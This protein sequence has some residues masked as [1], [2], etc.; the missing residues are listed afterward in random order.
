MDESPTIQDG[1]FEKRRPQDLLGTDRIHHTL[2]VMASELGLCPEKWL[3]LMCTPMPRH[4]Q[5]QLHTNDPVKNCITVLCFGCTKW[6]EPQFFCDLST[7]AQHIL[8]IHRDMNTACP[9]PVSIHWM[10]RGVLF[11]AETSM[12]NNNWVIPTPYGSSAL[13]QGTTTPILYVPLLV[14]SIQKYQIQY[15]SEAYITRTVCPCVWTDDSRDTLSIS[16]R[17]TAVEQLLM[18]TQCLA[19]GQLSRASTCLS[20]LSC[21]FSTSS[22]P[23]VVLQIC[24]LKPILGSVFI[25]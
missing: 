4:K 6:H 16:I 21:S 13:E 11:A 24:L 9:W 10:Q 1:S 23:S 18:W 25:R 15:I 5:Y 17:D 12:E 14:Y 7:E 22:T 8:H 2:G 3:A 19:Q 20:G